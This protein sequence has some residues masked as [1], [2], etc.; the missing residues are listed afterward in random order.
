MHNEG[1]LDLSNL[2]FKDKQHQDL[3]RAECDRKTE[4]MHRAEVAERQKV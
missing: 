3:H 2:I 4:G 1:S